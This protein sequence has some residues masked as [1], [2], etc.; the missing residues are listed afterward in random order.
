MRRRPEGTAL[1]AAAGLGVATAFS[2]AT[3]PLVALIALVGGVGVALGLLFADALLLVLVAALPWEGALDWPSEQL[4]VVKVLGLLLY[5]AWAVRA[6]TNRERVRLPGELVVVV[7]VGMSVLL[8]LMLSPDPAAGVLDTTRYA[9]FI[10]FAFLLVQ[11][12]RT[13]EQVRR[14]IAVIVLSGGAAGLWG[15]YAFV[16]GGRDR[17]GGPIRDPNDFA[18]LLASLTPLAIYLIGADPTRRRRWQGCSSC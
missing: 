6:L 18:F 13:R 16:L 5:V 2:A 14:V 1:L 8:A 11:L 10:L 9:L 7:G 3:A 15:L 12:V 4:S 17:A